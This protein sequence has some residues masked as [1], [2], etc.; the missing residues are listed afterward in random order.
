MPGFYGDFAM[1]SM[2]GK[3]SYFTN[4]MTAYQDKTGKTATLIELPSLV[5]VTDYKILGGNY[6][7]GIYPGINITKDYTGRN[8]QDRL[9]AAD[10]YLMPLAVNWQWEH[11]SALFYEG[12]IAPTG[13]Y[14]KGAVNTSRNVWTFDHI[15]SLTWQLPADN[16]VSTTLGYMNNL[17]NSATGY[18][19][20][21]ELH[22]DYL[23]GHYFNP[24]LA[25][26]LAGSYYQQITAD[27]APSSILAAMPSEASSIGP[28]LMLTPHLLAR[29]VIFSVKWLHE[30]NV[31]GRIA[32]DYLVCRVFF[33]F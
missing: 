16:E 32:Q 21:D 33:A 23:L 18:S 26:G 28:A 24:Q 8:K 4:F 6:I 30:Y 2:P 25:M 31:Q 7:A 10:A 20:G 1:G 14:A 27:H 9:G 11:F 5:Q 15:L 22:F 3:G 19:S 13:Y 17:K 12:I 29:D